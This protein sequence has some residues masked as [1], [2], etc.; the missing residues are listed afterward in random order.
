MQRS[1][2][3]RHAEL[4]DF[5]SLSIKDEPLDST[6]TASR[7]NAWNQIAA[8]R[9]TQADVSPATREAWVNVARKQLFSI[10]LT[11]KHWLIA[12][13]AGAKPLWQTVALFEA[14]LQSAALW[15]WLVKMLGIEAETVRGDI[16]IDRE[17]LFLAMPDQPKYAWPATSAHASVVYHPQ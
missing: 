15:D 6:E 9:A 3:V 16:E 4:P 17:Q 5:D 14:F 1:P 2:H 10:Q 11:R 8:M 13:R 7:L 12:A